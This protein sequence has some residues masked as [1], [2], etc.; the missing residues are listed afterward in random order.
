MQ[1]VAV[2]FLF[3]AIAA[4]PAQ[5]QESFV[6]RLLMAKHDHLEALEVCLRHVISASA[7]VGTKP[8]H[9]ARAAIKT[10]QKRDAVV[11]A[12]RKRLYGF[13]STDNFMAGTDDRIFAFSLSLANAH[14]AS[15]GVRKPPL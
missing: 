6:P 14:V 12:T 7:V 9:I 8:E 1:K 11:R 10:C 4:V 3:L 5:G 13:P 2:V 15:Q